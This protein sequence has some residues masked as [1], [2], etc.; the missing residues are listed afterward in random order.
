MVPLIGT[1]LLAGPTA[2][3]AATLELVPSSLEPAPPG[4]AP[5]TAPRM[6]TLT[7]TPTH[8]I[9]PVVPP[10]FLPHSLPVTPTA[11]RADLAALV[12][13]CVAPTTPATSREAPATPASP[14]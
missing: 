12:A 10:G 4:A 2:P 6:A 8:W 9:A 7:S 14:A 3:R 1:P 11:P 5:L 13:F